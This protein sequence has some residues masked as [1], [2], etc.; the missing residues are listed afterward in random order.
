MHA[1]ATDSKERTA[2]PIYV[3][4]A[5]LLVA[6]IVIAIKL[7]MAWWL[8]APFVLAVYAIIS[9]IFDRQ[10]WRWKFLREFG[11][12]RVPD[13]NGVWSGQIASSFDNFKRQ[14]PVNMQITQNW[15]TIYITLT[16]EKSRSHSVLAGITISN[17]GTSTLSYEYANEPQGDAVYTMQ[18]HIGRARLI[19]S[20][21]H[22]KDVLS[23]DY[24]SGGDR[25][26]YG[27]ISLE[28]AHTL[29]SSPITVDTESP[30]EIPAS[31]SSVESQ[32]ATA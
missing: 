3:A 2:V 26:T 1:Y 29:L 19:L 11:L 23:G 4:G 21:E 32:S 12:V 8:H 13:L 15:R 16:T 25:H 18:V 27:V 9:I 10:L 24:Y 6:W 22:D 7:P 5:T 30:S 20:Q 14:I 31:S 28:R 17:S